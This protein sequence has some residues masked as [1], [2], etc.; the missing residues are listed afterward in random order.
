MPESAF[1]QE[2]LCEF[3]DNGI[4]LFD[5]DLIKAAVQDIEAMDFPPRITPTL[6]RR[7]QGDKAFL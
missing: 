4:Q 2:Y 6:G 3:A 7:R 5:H 1:R